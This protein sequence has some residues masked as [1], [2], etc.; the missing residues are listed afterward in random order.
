M[1]IKRILKQ[2]RIILENFSYLTVLQIFT[3]LCPLITYPYL[4]HVLG[5]ELYGVVIFAQTL[6]IHVSLIINFGFNLSASKSIAINR[7]NKQIL[8]EIVSA[9]YINKLLIWIVC[10]AVYLAIIGFIP[11][12]Q[13][14]YLVYLF[15]FLITFNEL[16]FPIWFFQGIEKMKYTTIIN[17]TIRSL[18][19]VAIFAVIKSEQ[20]YLYIPLLNGIGAILAGITA[21]YIVFKKEHVRFVFLSVKKIYLY[22]K[23]SVPLFISIASIQVYVNL[24]KIII[25]T[26]LGMSE[27][28]VYD[29]G[30]KIAHLLKIPVDM[31]SNAVFPKISREK[32]I[33]FI[34]RIMFI[35]VSIVIA[36]YICVFT[37][38]KWIV[39]FFM[40]EYISHAIDIVRIIG[41]SSI[42]VAFNLFL[43]RCRLIPFGYDKLYM[44]ILLANSCFFLCCIGGLWLFKVLNLYTIAVTAVI[45]E[46]CCFCLA[47][48]NNKKL[49][50]LYGN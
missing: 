38:S 37:G 31:L 46:L 12:F 19:I 18:F 26:F 42:I 1:N 4:L 39:L 40:G 17:I 41:L 35:A 5:K 44:K 7:G 20:D 50:L 48:Y 13:K 32:N 15:S 8:S 21:T 24:N 10:L 2:N 28:T 29:L 23:E 34:N 49:N 33:Y 43:L 36:G 3:I 30:E 22:F 25:G 11:F 6:I 45:V 9:V 16:L 47:I 27:V 14:Y